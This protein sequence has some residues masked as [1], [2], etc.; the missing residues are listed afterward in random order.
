MMRKE[1]KMR[2]ARSHEKGNENTLIEKWIVLHLVDVI[3]I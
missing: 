2:F 1:K 3:N